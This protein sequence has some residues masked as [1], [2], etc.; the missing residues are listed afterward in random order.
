[1]R[2]TLSDNKQAGV[3]DACNTT[4]RFLGDILNITNIYFVNMV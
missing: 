3:I 2:G 1:M 4:S